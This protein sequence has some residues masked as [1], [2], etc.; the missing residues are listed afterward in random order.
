MVAYNPAIWSDPKYGVAEWKGG[1]SNIPFVNVAFQYV[2][3]LLNKGCDDIVT[4]LAILEEAAGHNPQVIK[5][6]GNYYFAVTLKG[7]DIVT[8]FRNLV[9]PARK[10]YGQTDW[11]LKGVTAFNQKKM[12]IFF[13]RGV[14]LSYSKWFMNGGLQ[15]QSV[16]WA[17]SNGNPTKIF[18][19]GNL[20]DMRNN[21][22]ALKRKITHTD[23]Y[24]H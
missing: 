4:D 3:Q 14:Q 12:P 10:Q 23:A 1:T 11:M 20:A 18:Y 13:L 21:H 7:N 24:T 5:Y 22:R 9:Q 2:P 15:L 19:V 8:A 17:H 6:E 16:D